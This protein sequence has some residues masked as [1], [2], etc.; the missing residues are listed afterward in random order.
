MPDLEE[1]KYQEITWDSFDITNW[2]DLGEVEYRVVCPGVFD[3][4]KKDAE[5]ASDAAKGEEFLKKLDAGLDQ[6]SKMK[7]YLT[8]ECLV[9]ACIA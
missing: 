8:G 7:T 5:L 4:L 3:A 1:Y 9:Y 2:E 6:A